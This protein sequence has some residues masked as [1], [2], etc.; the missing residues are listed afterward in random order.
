MPDA[1]SPASGEAADRWADL[2]PDSSANAPLYLGLADRVAAAVAHGQLRPGEALPPE[3]ALAARLGL[4]RTTVRK[5]VEELAGRGLVISRHGSGTYVAP[6]ID[7]PLARLS[8]F[9][10]DVRARGQEPGE[11]WIE[12]TIRLPSPEEMMA[13]GL[14]RGERVASL[15]RVRQADGEPLAIERAMVPASRLPDPQ[16][17]STSLYA[18]LRARGVAPVRALQRLRAA[19][20]SEA[21]ARKLGIAPGSPVMA[22]VRHGF[23]GDG[24][25]VEFTRSTCRGDRYDFVA[26]MRRD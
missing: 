3:R 1:G 14:G 26:E 2:L 20:A 10:E 13:L 4:S 12:R 17:V 15:V 21:D 9:S 22:I 25:P 5:A 24:V 18:V 8:S 23:L 6:R 16:S 11:I 7:Q 19:A